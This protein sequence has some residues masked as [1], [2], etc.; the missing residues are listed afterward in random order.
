MTTP[1]AEPLDLAALAERHL[2]G[3]GP[4]RVCMGGSVCS[5]VGYLAIIE[6]LVGDLQDV[7]DQLEGEQAQRNVA[8]LAA[9]AQ[10]GGVRERLDDE[11]LAAR[12]VLDAVLAERDRARD[13]AV[14]L[15]SE[16][17]RSTD[18]RLA[19]AGEMARTLASRAGQHHTEL[20][21]ER[22]QRDLRHAAW[23]EEKDRADRAGQ[24]LAQ[25]RAELVATADA[26]L[27]LQLERDGLAAELR[28]AQADASARRTRDSP[29]AVDEG[30]VA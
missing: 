14:A 22:Q 7:R 20:T 21:H 26:A 28:T 2:D 25:L 1:P 8:A 29:G 27:A 23:L 19:F 9:L 12:L 5:S 4:S 16:V 17:A 13:V 24:D 3:H 18:E 15:E 10:L 30:G 6:A 11:R